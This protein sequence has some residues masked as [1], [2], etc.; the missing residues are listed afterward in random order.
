[1]L[2]N[3]SAADCTTKPEDFNIRLQPYQPRPTITGYQMEHEKKRKLKDIDPATSEEEPGGTPIPPQID[4]A[5]VSDVMGVLMELK[6]L[7][8]VGASLLT[9]FFPGGLEFNSARFFSNREKRF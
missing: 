9:V 8:K 5:G 6:L 2:Q 7:P 1:M 3:I 4:G